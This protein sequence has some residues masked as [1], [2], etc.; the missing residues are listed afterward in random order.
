MA[1][2]CKYLEEKS[3]QSTMIGF[4]IDSSKLKR[5]I[6]Y[7]ESWLIRYKVPYE[8]VEK[9]H[10][11]VAQ[12]TSKVKKDELV[13]LVNKIS[14]QPFKFNIK[15]PVVLP[16]REWDFISLELKRNPKFL[17]L[18]EKIKQEYNVREFPG[19]VRP[20]ISLIRITPGIATPEFLSDV[21]KDVPL[22]KEIKSKEVEL[23]NPRFKVEY[24]KK[25]RI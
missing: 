18:F 6:D 3:M 13:R 2:F 25:K 1:K 12:I 8:L 22:P 10:I 19:G 11:S 20:H 14:N 15:K 23:W 5:T 24:K 4:G 7:I 9:N 16:G 17:E 21:M